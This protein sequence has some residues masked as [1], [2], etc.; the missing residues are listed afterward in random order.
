MRIDDALDLF[1]EHAVGGMI[2]LLFNAFFASSDIIALDDVNTS[3]VGGWLDQNWKQLYMQFAYIC[4]TSGYAF[5]VTALLAKCVDL[6]PGLH[7]RSTPEGERLGMDEIEVRRLTTLSHCVVMTW[8]RLGNSQMTTSRSEETLQTDSYRTTTQITGR[9]VSLTPLLL[10]GTDT[11][12]LKSIF[13]IANQTIRW[14]GLQKWNKGSWK[15]C[16]RKQK[17]AGR[18]HHKLHNKVLVLSTYISLL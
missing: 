5:V 2:G 16:R 6:I 14:R 8:R 1:A 17:A 4:A 10:L 7:L 12:M 11:G 9:T 15:L 13:S 3:A 18:H